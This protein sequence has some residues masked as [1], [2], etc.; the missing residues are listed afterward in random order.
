[1]RNPSVQRWIFG[2]IA[3]FLESGLERQ[4]PRVQEVKGWLLEHLD[5]HYALY[6]DF[7]GLRTARK[8]IGWAVAAL[9]GGAE[10]RDRMNR[11][12]DVESQRRS[13]AE[14]FDAL[15]L[16]HERLPRTAPAGAVSPS[17]AEEACCP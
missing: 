13:L 16:T 3:H 9:P 15:S 5:D 2:D 14:F 4:P 11:I 10:Y 6:G 17:V 8:H 1:M 12:E 7:I